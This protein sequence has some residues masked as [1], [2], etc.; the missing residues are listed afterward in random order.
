MCGL[1][2][3]LEGTLELVVPSSSWELAQEGLFLAK[4]GMS[5][6]DGGVFTGSPLM[7]VVVQIC[8]QLSGLVGQLAA[9]LLHAGIDLLCGLLLR[10][11]CFRVVTVESTSREKN[12]EKWM[13][14]DTKPT[15]LPPWTSG[16][17]GRDISR[18]PDA[19]LAA[20]L[21]NPVS[22]GQCV[23]LSGDTIGRLF[24]LAALA[25]AQAG[26]SALSSAFLA[27]GACLWRFHVA[28]LLAPA[29][30]MVA[31][32]R[33]CAGP[34]GA[35]SRTVEWKEGETEASSFDPRSF[36]FPTREVLE[37]PVSFLAWCG[38]ILGAC[39][40]W[41]SRSWVF[42][43][44]AMG[45][46]LLCEDLTPNVG[47]YWYFF[48]EIFPRFRVF[49]R[50]L[51]LSHP[52]VYILPATLR[53]GM[54]PDVLAHLLLAIFGIF[55]TYPTL[56]DVMLSA[57][58][59]MCHPRTA[60]RMRLVA[61]LA[62]MGVIPTLLMPT[63]RHLWLRAGTGN[64]NFYYFQTVIFNVLQCVFVLQFGAAAVKRR[65]ALSTA[66]ARKGKAAGCK[67]SGVGEVPVTAGVVGSAVCLDHE[68]EDLMKIRSSAQN[69]DA[70]DKGVVSG[71]PTLFSRP[72]KEEALG[73][74]ACATKIT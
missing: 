53:L 19:V 28:V 73:I 1:Q 14:E 3:M 37:C 42:L 61:P 34:S 46:Q 65:K 15:V 35:K 50:V 25:A 62:F 60:A 64:A 68:E 52:Y 9:I 74:G 67:G 2:P 13:D 56:G 44:A 66:M 39:W 21:L 8:N 55:Q 5:P 63:M 70:V 30:L 16:N 43:R 72:K 31:R 48:T 54:F 6:Y 4:S 57:C 23:A 58:L 38:V 40:L 51:F 18:L 24:P 10:T 22:I 41:T 33:T 69:D 47:L 20:F 26:C 32:A 71:K 45:A 11:I 59:F 17:G 29:V 49:F 36:P 27:A 12:L 7:L